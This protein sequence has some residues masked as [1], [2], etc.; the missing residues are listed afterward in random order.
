MLVQGSS[1]N[2]ATVFGRLRSLLY[3]LGPH[4][5]LLSLAIASGIGHQLV[6]LMSATTA[7]WLVG[8]SIT[9]AAASELVSGLILLGTLIIPVVIL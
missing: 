2:V 1:Q 4:R 5:T 8:R 7:A 9:G 6:V 3:L